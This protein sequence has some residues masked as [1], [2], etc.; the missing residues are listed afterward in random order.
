MKKLHRQYDDMMNGIIA[1]R[2][3][4]VK[5]AGDDEGKDLLGL[6]LTM[7]QEELRL[8]GGEHDTI[9]NTHVKAL[10]LVSFIVFLPPIPPL[11]K[12]TFVLS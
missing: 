2:R 11:T 9:T 5:P 8:G 12:L 10:I 3:A 7:V 4:G 6:L 1:D